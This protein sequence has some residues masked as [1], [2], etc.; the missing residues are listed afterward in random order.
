[1]VIEFLTKE[2]AMIEMWQD[3]K[4]LCKKIYSFISA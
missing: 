2:E 1:M 3:I 4:Y